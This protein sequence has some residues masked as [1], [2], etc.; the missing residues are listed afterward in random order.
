MTETPDMRYRYYR[1]SME[2]LRLSRWCFT[3]RDL[4]FFCDHKHQPEED[5]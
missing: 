1:D 4:R 2:T 5:A 3:H